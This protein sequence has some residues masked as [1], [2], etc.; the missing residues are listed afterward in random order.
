MSKE[1]AYTYEAGYRDGLKEALVENAKLRREF[2]TDESLTYARRSLSDL[3]RMVE[4]MDTLAAENAKLRELVRGLDYCSDELNS[5][6]CDRCPLHDATDENLE[7]KCV[8]MM[9]EM[10]I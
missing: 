7:P 4:L 9:R 5:A 6:E 8:R 2:E 1:H 3:N 10:K